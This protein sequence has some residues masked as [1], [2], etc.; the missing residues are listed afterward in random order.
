MI[1][2]WVAEPD[3][4][5]LSERVLWIEPDGE[6]VFVISIFNPKSLP[7]MRLCSE[8]EEALLQE[9]AIRRTV[10]P[11]ASLATMHVDA[12]AKHLEIRDRVWKRIEALVAQQPDIY[13]E[14]KRKRLI[15]NDPDAS[16]GAINKVYDYLRKYWKRGMIRN[17]LLPDYGNCGAPG[18]ERGIKDGRKRGRKPKVTAVAPEQIGVNVDE[19]IKRIFNIAFKRY[20]D[21]REKNSLKRAYEQMIEKH[22][23]L[24]YRRQGD[25]QIPIAP[26]AYL[27]PTLGQFN[28]WYN[29]QNNLVH[30]IVARE[31]RRA[32]VLKHRPLLG[33]STSMAFGP[34]SIYQI[35]ATVADIYL[36]WSLDRSKIIG[37]PVVY[38]CIDVLSRLCVGLH[39]A[40]EGPSWMTGMMALANSTTDKVSFCAEYG[41]DITQE[42]WPCAHLPEQILADRGEFIGVMSDY[43]VDS[44][45][46]PF[47]NCP[48]YRGDLKGIVERAFR[49]S[50][51]TFI[52]WMPGA[53]RKREQ[54]DA[55]YRLDATLTLF[56]FTK[57]L[58]LTVIEYNLFHRMDEYPIDK[59]MM[60]DGVEPI[61]ID[62]WNWGIVNRTGHLREKSP[63]TIRLSLLP[64]DNAS[65]TLK[66]IRFKG[67]F[68]SCEL[69]IQEQWF[70]RARKS[71]VWSM[72][73]SY[74]PRK[75]EVIYL[76]LGGGKL[77]PCQLLPKDERFSNLPIEEILEY[78]EIQKQNS[79]L[80]KS[81]RMES[82]G[83]LNTMVDHVVNGAHEQT[84]A[85]KNNPE[86]NK[87][88]LQHIRGNRSEAK[89]Q[90]RD[91][92]AWDL[93][94][95]SKQ[96]NSQDQHDDNAGVSLN[97]NS[98]IISLATSKRKSFLDAIKKSEKEEG[99]E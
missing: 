86:S 92:Q 33:N 54:G 46:I 10:D 85:A 80:Y 65:V 2:E 83:E 8:I 28:Y 55:D 98:N 41:I 76:H 66:G 11:Y 89:N 70:V 61:P 64:R 5:P 72:T 32:Y 50:N 21:S 57:I 14:E 7:I 87:S 26:P 68:Y 24:G 27:V 58:I 75:P 25:L 53:V 31:G 17:A 4:P 18:K 99:G 3:Q 12:P 30:S 84:K 40:L 94:P 15:L 19:D 48:P 88:K 9:H 45:N 63:D 37:R 47:A 13:L 71:G 51:D 73:A 59:D 82:S 36:V 67:M 74:D 60:V 52:K 43:L 39:V 97:E 16:Q 79:A 49:R 34:G 6:A 62:L 1:L 91:E 20:Y 81:R 96:Q 44:L 42:D 35:D 23:N 22:F 90:L 78:Q 38:L 93:R 56:E 77:E 95:Q 29:R 69:A